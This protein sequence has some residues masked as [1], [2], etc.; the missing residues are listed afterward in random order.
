MDLKEFEDQEELRKVFWNKF[1]FQELSG[2]YLKQYGE[3]M[4]LSPDVTSPDFSAQII[5]IN[6]RICEIVEIWNQTFPKFRMMDGN[7]YLLKLKASAEPSDGFFVYK[8]GLN[9]INADYDENILTST[10][11]LKQNGNLKK[12]LLLSVIIA[13]CALLL[14]IF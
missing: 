7:T 12:Y 1:I 3:N 11:L 5:K 8:Y 14:L 6:K 2:I 13:C 9:E 10:K 4:N